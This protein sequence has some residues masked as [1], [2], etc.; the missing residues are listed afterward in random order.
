MSA[1]P[2]ASWTAFEALPRAHGAPLGQGRLRVLPQ[3]FEVEEALGLTPDGEGEHLLLWVRKIGANTDWVARRLA[4]L[5]G[6]SPSA[7]G[8]AGLK[9]RHAVTFQWFSLPCRDDAVPDWSPLAD[10]GVEVLRVERHRRKLRRGVLAGNRFRILVRD[11][12]PPPEA[13]GERLDRLRGRGVPNYFGEQRFGREQGNLARADALF[14]GTL[15]RVP[16]HQRGLWLSAARS[17]IFNEVLAQRVRRG[18]WDQLLPGECVRLDGTRSHFTAPVTAL[19]ADLHRRCAELDLHP[20]GPLWGAGPLSSAGEAAAL[21][22][23]VGAGLE[24]WALGL[25][26]FGLEQ[27]RRV[28]RLR[29]DDLTAEPGPDGLTLRFSLPAG[30]YATTVLRELVAWD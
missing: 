1:P 22:Q 27:E 28:L 17:Q 8:Y 5:A 3:D 7:V 16:R 23:A 24:A 13:L 21:E 10:A 6:V 26:A 20:S 15:R 29:L 18:D 4:Q 25:A 2:R 12:A 9:D 14:A 30:A 19:D 11:L